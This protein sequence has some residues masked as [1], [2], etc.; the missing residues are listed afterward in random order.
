MITASKHT[1]FAAAIAL[2]ASSAQ[3]GA[4]LAGTP[5]PGFARIM[6]GD[7]EITPLSDGTADLPMDQLLQQKAD[8]TRA[9]LKQDYLTLP[10]ETS[11]NAFLVNT[12]ARLV[13]VDTGAGGFFGPTLGKLA[14]NLKAAGYRPEQ[15]DEIYITHLHPDHVGGLSE[16]GQRVFPNA[17]VRAAKADSDYWLNQANA[18]KAPADK[19]GF[20]QPAMQSLGPYVQA[21]RFKAIERDGELVAGIS[22][23][24]AAGH[25]P[26]HTVYQ[27]QSRGLTLLLI[28]DLVHVASVQMAHPEV[29]IGFDS[30]GKRAYAA[31]R[32]FFDAAGKEGELVGGAHLQFPG[33]G[34][35]AP[36]G[37]AY[38]WVPLN[39]SR[40]P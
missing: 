19:Q 14:A 27:V 36:Q 35:L 31:R 11:T 1:L 20:F 13:L 22:A 16:N 10:L 37:Q 30:D 34:R 18:A 5:A 23:L 4:P 28:G 24:S 25:T 17:V 29:T 8:A 21:G 9:A 33:L 39:Y 6:L 32:K 2:L 40:L 15:V 3:A 12:G 26:G 38:R 7:F